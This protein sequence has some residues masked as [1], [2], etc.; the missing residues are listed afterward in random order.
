QRR[1][2]ATTWN[3]GCKSW[4]LTEDGYNGTMYPGFANQFV[5]QMARVKTTDYVMTPHTSR[6]LRSAKTTAKPDTPSAAA[7][8]RTAGRRDHKVA[9][10]T[11]STTQMLGHPEHSSSCSQE[12]AGT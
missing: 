6:L 8:T 10:G 9:P 5:R 4:Y 2:A 3:S 7:T 11:A 1:L 12:R